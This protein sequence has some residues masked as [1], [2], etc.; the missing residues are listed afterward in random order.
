MG[1]VGSDKAATAQAEAEAA[2]L[3][4]A[5]RLFYSSLVSKDVACMERLW[6]GAAADASVSEAVSQG[7]R[8]EPW[9]VN[10]PS[11]PPP[12]MRATDCDALILSPEEAWTTAIERPGEGGTLLASQRWRRVGND[13][14]LASHRYIPWSADG[15]TAIVTLR[16]DGRGCVLLGREINTRDRRGAVL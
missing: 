6:E 7:A 11:F 15:A 16:C 8:I 14:L 3:L 9:A 1:W 5:Q 10:S 12:D 13:W 4:E 2:E